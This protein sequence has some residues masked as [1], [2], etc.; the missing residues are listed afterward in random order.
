MLE[1][2]PEFLKSYSGIFKEQLNSIWELLNILK[3]PILIA[4]KQ[5][6][7]PI[8]PIIKLDKQITLAFLLVLRRFYQLA[9]FI[10][11]NK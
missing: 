8:T 2:D 4:T 11:R 3:A 1:K 6:I 5:T 10:K 7:F 9:L